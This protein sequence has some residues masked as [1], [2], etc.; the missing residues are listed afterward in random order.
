M[1]EKKTPI[2]NMN[3]LGSRSIISVGDLY[4]HTVKRMDIRQNGDHGSIAFIKLSLFKDLESFL[5]SVR[6]V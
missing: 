4:T 1:L 3:T 5:H 2:V 6:F